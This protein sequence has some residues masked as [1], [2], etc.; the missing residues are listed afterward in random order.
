MSLSEKKEPAICDSS[1][2]I[3]IIIKRGNLFG[4]WRAFSYGES[5]LNR[6]FFPSK[7]RGGAK[8]KK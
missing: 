4:F 2:S 1:G 5:H 7:A 3:K 6:F 8:W